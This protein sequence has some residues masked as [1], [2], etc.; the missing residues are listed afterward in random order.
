[1]SD[2]Y[3]YAKRNIASTQAERVARASDTSVSVGNSRAQY[4]RPKLMHSGPFVH[5]TEQQPEPNAWPWITLDVDSE[6]NYMLDQCT[7]F[8]Q[9]DKGVIDVSLR[10]IAAT[11]AAP[12][13]L[14]TDPKEA[15]SI[16]SVAFTAKLKQFQNDF[17]T[18]NTFETV[19]VNKNIAAYPATPYPL[20]PVLSLINLGWIYF[21]TVGYNKY[22]QLWGDPFTNTTARPPQLYERDLELM[23][24]VLIQIP[25]DV[26][27]FD[28]QYPIICE[29]TADY[30]NYTIWSDKVTGNNQYLDLEYVR[31]FNVASTM[32]DRGTL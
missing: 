19:T 15:Q 17:T 22:I 18:P 2:F 24:T 30:G 4:F 27:D 12:S 29:V 7:F 23:Q 9:H 16:F 11:A 21:D 5:F 1:M 3:T 8:P 10:I 28:P 6:K 26:A 32:R 25:Y 20:Y 14:E 13:I 31:V